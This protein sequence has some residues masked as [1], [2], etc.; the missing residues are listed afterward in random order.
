MTHPRASLALGWP[1]GGFGLKSSHRCITCQLV[2]CVHLATGGSWCFAQ[3]VARSIQE[4]EV[5]VFQ[6]V[7]SLLTE[8]GP[9]LGQP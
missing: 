6:G 3:G 1:L 5:Y 2:L 9:Y 7:Y 8:K 4:H